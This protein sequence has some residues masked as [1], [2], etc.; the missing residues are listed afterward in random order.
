MKRL[1]V[2]FIA[3]WSFYTAPALAEKTKTDL[4]FF[5]PGNLSISAD[6]NGSIHSRCWNRMP[7]RQAEALLTRELEPWLAQCEEKLNRVAALHKR[8]FS[9]AQVLYCSLSLKPHSETALTALDSNWS[10]RQQRLVLDI[11]QKSTPFT[12]PPNFLPY[13]S[14]L[15]VKFTDAGV[16]LTLGASKV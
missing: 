14:G 7:R 1:L 13:R 5:A 8:D 9:S 3:G 15:L 6:S 12:R 10:T 4:P 11:I 2:T 16:R